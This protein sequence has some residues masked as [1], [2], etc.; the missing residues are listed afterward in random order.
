MQAE[1]DSSDEKLN[2]AA[3][4]VEKAER[5]EKAALGQ[6]EQLKA[7]AAAQAEESHRAGKAAAIRRPSYQMDELREAL[8]HHKT[9]LAEAEFELLGLRQQLR[10]SRRGTSE[11]VGSA[12]R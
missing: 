1:L 11:S 3:L 9:K 12:A 6:V 10:V 4:R 5:R 8:A 7:L 2:H